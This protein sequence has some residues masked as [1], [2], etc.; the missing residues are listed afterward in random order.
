MIVS[1]SKYGSTQLG[2]IQS[3]FPRTLT[4]KGYSI[5]FY[6][7]CSRYL[8]CLR[9]RVTFTGSEGLALQFFNQCL[10]FHQPVGKKVSFEFGVS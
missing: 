8:L 9:V 6:S 7:Q 2:K 5:Q 3:F 10:S 1:M 4:I